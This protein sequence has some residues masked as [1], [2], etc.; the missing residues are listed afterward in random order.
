MS[1]AGTR[2]FWSPLAL[3]SSERRPP[4]LLFFAVIVVYVAIVVAVALRHEPWRDEAESWLFVRDTSMATMFAR[5]PYGGTPALWFLLLRPIVHSGLPYVAERLTNVV[6]AAAAVAL[7]TLAAPFTRLTK[8]L[9][10]FSYF[11]AY[12]Y[13]V[14]AR[15]Y[16]LT[17]LLLFA[18]A[19]AWRQRWKRPLILAGAVALAANTTV[20]GL[21]IAAIA[22][23]AFLYE[24]IRL[25]E[26]RRAQT[27]ISLVLMLAGGLFAAWELRTLPDTA[28]PGVVR[29]IH[30][31]MAG[32]AISNAFFPTLDDRFS[33]V[34]SLL[35]LLALTLALGGR[36]IALL[37]LWGPLLALMTVYSF[38][39]AGG[40]RHF[41]LLL[42]TTLFAVWIADCYG[43]EEQSMR[44]H[45]GV[46]AALLLNAS[47]AFSLLVAVGYW[48]ADWRFSF[49]GA[50]EMAQFIRVNHLDRYDIAAHNLT[51]CEALL[52][53]LPGKRFW[54]AGL[55]AYG[56]YMLWDRR[57]EQ[58]LRVPYP[59][60]ERRAVRHFAGRPWLLLFNVE[61]P[62]PAAHGFRLLYANHDFV[63][64]NRDER[65][66]LYA[67]LNWPAP[68]IGAPQ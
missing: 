56:S 14:I 39:W 41:G 29:M 38:V 2:K 67:P 62:N 44:K 25:R 35:L 22:G 33:F 15:P 6:I 18:I 19:A 47:L 45:A 58:A 17:I 40:M 20:H 16:A 64:E 60:A 36:T 28:Y 50:Q 11:M 1:E 49:S 52:P 57:M 9:F 27:S 32:V 3:T 30:P 13:A 51:Q 53:Y 24:S 48:V 7:F 61:I 54:Y 12:E 37:F 46:A 10:A 4:R 43:R 59:V 42:I 63:F 68:P 55:G 34:L 66:W 8:V 65:F 23:A 31:A 21:V 26:I 5:L